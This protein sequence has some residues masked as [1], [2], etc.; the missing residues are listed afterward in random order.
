MDVESLE[1]LR[2]LEKDNTDFLCLKDYINI[3]YQ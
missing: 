3:F 2:A 1:D